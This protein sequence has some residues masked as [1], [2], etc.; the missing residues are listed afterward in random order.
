MPGA[1]GPVVLTFPADTANAALARTVGAAMA[2]RADLPID[3]LEDVRLA[4][5]EAVAQV[6]SGASSDSTVSCQ[7]TVADS[8]LEIV[9]CGAWSPTEPPP[10]GSFGW[11]ILT[12]LCDRVHAHLGDGT[13]TL[14]LA[15][16]RTVNAG[17]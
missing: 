7:F 13:L 5:D 9:V 14:T 17:A 16:L 6:L 3:R 10:T 11:T 1:H 12:A 15:V 4:V 2:A 8:E